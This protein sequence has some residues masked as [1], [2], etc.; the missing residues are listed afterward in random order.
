MCPA[1]TPDTGL[2]KILESTT[3][4]HVTGAGE[5]LDFSVPPRLDA[6]DLEDP[7]RFHH[8]LSEWLMAQH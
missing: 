7:A 6:S 4:V 1:P 8:R 3:Y 5:E 2:K